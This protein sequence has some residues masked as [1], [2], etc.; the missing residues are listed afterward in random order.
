MRVTI[1]LNCL[2]NRFRTA[3]PTAWAS[4][5]FPWTVGWS[6]LACL[7]CILPAI[8]NH[9]QTPTR[10]ATLDGPHVVSSV[11]SLTGPATSPAESSP[12]A[13]GRPHTTRSRRVR[14]RIN[15]C[16]YI[17]TL[18]IGNLNT[19]SMAAVRV[20]ALSHLMQAHCIGVMAV[21]ETKL[22]GHL[23]EFDKFGVQYMGQPAQLQEGTLTGGTGFFVGDIVVPH[24]SYL[25]TRPRCRHRAPPKFAPVWLKVFG[26]E[27]AHDVYNIYNIYNISYVITPLC[28]YHALKVPAISTRTHLWTFRRILSTT[29]PSHTRCTWLEISTLAWVAKHRLP[30][31]KPC[32]QSPPC[33]EKRL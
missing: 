3:P 32:A 33:K 21:Q 6:R 8:G 7:K 29:W 30:S 25:G 16:D 26:L 31:R 23:R 9:H 20:G 1:A 28:T 15:D 12:T 22:M 2:L 18:N 10:T 11:A 13:L 17:G 24:V 4:H 19:C 14:S 27:P 5:A